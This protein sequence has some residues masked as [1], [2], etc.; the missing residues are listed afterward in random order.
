MNLKHTV[1]LSFFTIFFVA[2]CGAENKLT[3]SSEISGSVTSLKSITTSEQAIRAT[4]QNY[5][6]GRRNA[7]IALLKKAYS[8][9]A[10]LM[11][12]GPDNQLIVISLE[13]YFAV[14]VKRGKV[15]VKTTIEDLKFEDQ[16]AFARVVFNYGDKSYTDF[17]LLIKSD[18]G[19]RIVNKSFKLNK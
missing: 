19:W 15:M 5:F 13:G 11:T 10:R 12:T 2:I 6:N 14:V 1:V 7:D 18:I 3:E 8:K 4:I 9:D 16:L 17:L